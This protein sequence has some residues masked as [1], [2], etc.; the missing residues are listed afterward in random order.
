MT[1]TQRADN[2]QYERDI[3]EY[4]SNALSLQ[5]QIQEMMEENTKLQSKDLLG[6]VDELSVE[7]ETLTATV[8]RITAVTA[9]LGEENQKLMD[10]LSEVDAQNE[11]L[12]KRVNEQ[13]EMDRVKAEERQRMKA[14]LEVFC[15]LNC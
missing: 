15:V 7:K 2:E 5:Q 14:Q 13:Q 11:A 12:K 4:Q 8:T 6:K 3:A 9:S 1:Q 10:R